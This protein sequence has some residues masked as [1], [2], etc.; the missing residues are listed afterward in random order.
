MGRHLSIWGL[1]RA[2]GAL[3]GPSS[4]WKA[5]KGWD[6]EGTSWKWERSG[7]LLADLINKLS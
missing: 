1:T 2:P 5:G 4:A 6:T 7:Y 3:S